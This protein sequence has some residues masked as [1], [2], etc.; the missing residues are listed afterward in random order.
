VSDTLPGLF[1]GIAVSLV[2]L[3]Y[4]SSRPHVAELGIVPATPAGGAVRFAD[5][6]R[7]PE[8]QPVP[9]V[10]VLRPEAGLFFAN[11]ESV[12]QVVRRH[13]A[14]PGTRTV[15]LDAQSV[16]FID[17][18]AVRML[19]ELAED[20]HRSG[21]VPVIAHSVGQVCDLIAPKGMAGVPVKVYASVAEAVDALGAGNPR[22]P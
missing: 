3:L 12:R 9:G 18:T 11:A 15:V 7:H 10:E 19:V 14:V 5:R 21:V 1:I 13:A 6:D 2:L 8:L 16:P 17:I 4:R 22:S 20:L